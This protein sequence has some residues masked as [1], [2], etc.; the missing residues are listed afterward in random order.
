VKT[1]PLH[2]RWQWKI[3]I[4]MFQVEIVYKTWK[5]EWHE[6]KNKNWE[7]KGNEIASLLFTFVA[8]RKFRRRKSAT[9]SKIHFM[10]LACTKSQKSS[11][12]S[13]K[14]RKKYLWQQNT[15]KKVLFIRMLRDWTYLCVWECALN[16]MHVFT[17]RGFEF[18]PALSRSKIRLS[19][20]K[21]KSVKKRKPHVS[22]TYMRKVSFLSVPLT[23]KLESFLMHISIVLVNTTKEKQNYMHKAFAHTQHAMNVIERTFICME[24][25]KVTCV[26]TK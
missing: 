11:I 8:L 22:K 24:V 14:T 12:F 10:Y 6:K 23:L 18:F 9:P 20:F 16:S 21:K 19:E 2:F 3:K 1:F 26:R 5:W 7:L 25:T 4:K 13:E 15:H 17:F